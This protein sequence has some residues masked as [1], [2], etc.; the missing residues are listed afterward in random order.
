MTKL[1]DV[2][3]AGAG[4]VGL[5]LAC[6]LR[7]AHASVLVLERDNKSDSPWKDPA[8]GRRGMNTLSTEHFYR[9]GLLNSLFNSGERPL[10]FQTKPGFQFGGHFAGI[11]V[12]ANKLDLSRH[13]YLFNGPS[14]IPALTSINTVEEVLTERAESLGVT[15]IRNDGLTKISE[16]DDNSVTVEAGEDGTFKGR[17]LVGCDGGRST[18]RKAAGFDFVG[19]EA[20]FTG[21]A[22]KCEWDHPERLKPGFHHSK[23]GFY[24]TVGPGILYLTDFDGGAFDRSQ[25][26]T[27]PHLQGIFTR[28][29]GITDVHIE[30]IHIVSSFTDRCKQTTSYRKGRILLAGDAAH[31]HGPVGSQ[32]LNVGLGDA[33][34][35]GWKLAATLRREAHAEGPLTEADLALIDTYERERHPMGAWV[36]DWTRGQVALMQPGE[37]IVAART[38]MRELADTTDGANMLIDRHWGLSQRY[39]LGDEHPLIG[40]S[41]PDFEL[42]GG[43][44]LGGKLEG[45]KGLLV[46]FGG[47]GSLRGS[48]DDEKYEAKVDYFGASAKD[49][50]GLRALLVRPDGIVAWV[51][52]EVT[53]PHI[54][55]LKAALERWFRY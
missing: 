15:I 14:L 23:N 25:P 26:I 8:L 3:I 33:M 19:T 17:W 34:N 52:E 7:L 39:D 21:Y 20:T 11:P 29:S 45:G 49:T 4:P 36:L 32:G 42:E 53:E 12:N 6:E 47:D 28:V 50:R 31:I 46:D 35:L 10:A 40:S 54:D 38:L 9:R 48:I 27:Q 18:V 1:Y 37:H 13:K 30:K 43:E 22:A 16:Q 2:V 24:I 41:M 5:F 55:A 51:A 44:R